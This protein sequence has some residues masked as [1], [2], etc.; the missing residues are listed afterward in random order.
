MKRFLTVLLA[1]VMCFATM[2][3]AT[4]ETDV[5]KA[6]AE[7]ATMTWDELLAKA[8]EEIGDNPLKGYGNASAEFCDNFTALTGIKTEYT[9][10][11]DVPLYVRLD[12]ELGSNTYGADVVLIQDSYSLQSTMLD[13]GYLLNYF[14]EYL[15][16]D[17]A[18]ED[19]NPAVVLYLNKLF[20]YNNTDGRTGFLKNVWQLAGT[21]ED[22]DH[23]SGC[24]FKPSSTEQVN[25][26]FLVMLTT[27][28]WCEKLAS[29]YES[30]YGKT[31]EN[32]GVYKNIGYKWIAEFLKNSAAHSSDGS[33]M[34]SVASSTVAGTMCLANYCKFKSL[35]TENQGI[36]TESRANVQVAAY[37]G[38]EGFAG[39]MFPMYAQVCYNAKYPYTSALMVNYMLSTECFDQAWGGKP[40]YYSANVNAPYAAEANDQPLS[41]WKECLVNEDP[42]LIT[43]N[44]TSVFKFISSLESAQ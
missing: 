15:K 26:N 39:F 25:M 20:V 31:W 19:Q 16:N 14:P 37:E 9:L 43:Q 27:D 40:G 4:A 32:D 13:A 2:S 34:K 30:Y 8:K 21:E 24:S 22:P 23:I 1:L 42:E 10:L 11:N 41:Y 29:A 5:E 3:M 38:V 18:V 44:Y 33:V 28:M 35:S 36:G 7:A 17:I 6:L 12:A